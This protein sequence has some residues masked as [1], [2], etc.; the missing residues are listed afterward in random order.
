MLLMNKLIISVFA[1]GLIFIISQTN[2]QK[3]K[4]MDNG[5]STDTLELIA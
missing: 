1:L 5:L 3:P 2:D 4:E